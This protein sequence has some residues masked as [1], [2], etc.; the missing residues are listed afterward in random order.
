[1]SSNDDL[2]VLLNI[3]RQRRE[4]ER[5]EREALER[6]RRNGLSLAEIGRFLGISRQAVYAKL[7]RSRDSFV[8]LLALLDDQDLLDALWSLLN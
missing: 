3:A 8:I 6:A 1:M 7:R 4:L 2:D 5:L